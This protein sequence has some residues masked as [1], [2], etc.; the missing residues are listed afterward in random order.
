MQIMRYLNRRILDLTSMGV[1][2][3]L[4]LFFFS[5]FLKEDI[6]TYISLKQ[7]LT[8][9]RSSAERSASLLEEQKKRASDIS[10]LELEMKDYEK[11][12]KAENK[13]PDFLNYITDIARRYR[14]EVATVEPGEVIKGDPFTRSM[15]TTVLS[16]SF[17][18]IYH[19]LYRIEEDWKA[20]KIEHVVMDKNR[21]DNKIQ[22]TLTLAVLSI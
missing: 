14:I 17:Y 3:V 8:S 22:V 10:A 2:V 18:D 11:I 20:V 9:L 13:T 1:I 7:R 6:S 15:Y 21:D 4:S 12:F 16:G 19:Y 5:I